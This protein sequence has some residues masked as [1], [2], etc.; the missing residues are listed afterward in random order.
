MAQL[1][2][3]GGASENGSRKKRAT[4]LDFIALISEAVAVPVLSDQSDS[5]LTGISRGVARVRA[6][7]L[8]LSQ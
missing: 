5:E 2:R 3:R 7:N 1:Q 4:G 6:E 8:E